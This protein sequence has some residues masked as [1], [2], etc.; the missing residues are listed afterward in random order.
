M[1]DYLRFLY[2]PHNAASKGGSR[3][4]RFTRA[5]PAGQPIEP[6]R[7]RRPRGSGLV[8]GAYVVER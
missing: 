2:G 8:I 6:A 3:G 4:R 7:D 5:S 1:I